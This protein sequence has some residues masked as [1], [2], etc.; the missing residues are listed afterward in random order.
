M[1]SFDVY[2]LGQILP[3][4]DPDAVRRNVAA[5]F[6]VSEDNAARLFSGKPLRVK[7]NID[8]EAASRYRAAFRDAGALLQILPAGSPP[9]Q[10]TAPAPMP[11][12]TDNVATTASA[13]NGM[14]LAAPG[15]IMDSTPPP[16]P[17]QIDTSGLSAQPPNSGSLED[18]RVEKDPYP[19]PDISHLSIIDN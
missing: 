5:L 6:K 16:P 8:A 3:N 11:P 7:Q 1:Q 14:S 9:P 15:A 10:P 4:A 12:S 19:I 13:E 18:C 2:F 17:A